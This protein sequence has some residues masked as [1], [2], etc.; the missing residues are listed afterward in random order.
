MGMDIYGENHERL[1]QTFQA[2]FDQAVAYREQFPRDSKEYE[3]AQKEVHRWYEEMHKPENEYF[4]V[5][6]NPYSLAWWIHYNLDESAKG[7]WGLEPFYSASEKENPI[8]SDAFRE[9]LVKTAKEWYE[10]ALDLKDQPS[11]LVNHLDRDA[12]VVLTPEDTNSYIDYLH[13]LVVFA[14][15][16]KKRKSAITVSA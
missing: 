3:E 10:K 1:T 5:S 8:R 7:S 15:T 6:Y 2:K 9:E 4:R 12:N 11:F 16:V 13:D 14:E